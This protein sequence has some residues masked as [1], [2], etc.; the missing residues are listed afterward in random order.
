MHRTFSGHA[1]MHR[2]FSGL[3]ILYAWCDA[4]LRMENRIQFEYETLSICLAQC[5]LSDK[6]FQAIITVMN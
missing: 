1:Y 2:T 6:S 4:F 3:S 5:Y